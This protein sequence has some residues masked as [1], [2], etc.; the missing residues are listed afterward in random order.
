MWTCVK[1]R[2]KS[3]ALDRRM[4][5]GMKMELQSRRLLKLLFCYF[6][7]CNWKNCN[8]VARGH[9]FK[10]ILHIMHNYYHNYPQ[11][12]VVDIVGKKLT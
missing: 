9:T 12:L 10:H 1:K 6:A 5:I 7:E 4:G 8:T 2:I 3:S 11:A